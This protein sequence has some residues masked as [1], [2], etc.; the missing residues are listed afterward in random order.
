GK[1]RP[2]GLCQPT[3][4]I[5]SLDRPR[6]R[7]E[8]TLRF[9]GKT[10]PARHLPAHP[11]GIANSSTVGSRSDV[12]MDRTVRVVDASADRKSPASRLS[13]Q[14]VER[15]SRCIKNQISLDRAQPCRKIR[16][17]RRGVFDVYPP[18]DPRPV[19]SSFERSIYLRRPASI[20]I[21]NKP[22][23]QPQIQRAVQLQP[24]R[25]ASRES[26]ISFQPEIRLF[27]VERHWIDVQLFC[28]C[29]KMD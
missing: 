16:H 3:E 21:G 15:K 7:K 10:K 23:Q 13:G 2:P 11:F 29:P 1:C 9:S 18:R 26:D 4:K 19:Q 5:P 25:A 6:A 22:A 14:V 27:S 8:S 28:R 20:Q 12:V 24:H 17:A